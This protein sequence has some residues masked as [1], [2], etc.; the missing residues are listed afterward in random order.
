MSSN[1][2]SKLIFRLSQ[3]EEAYKL[4]GHPTSTFDITTLFARFC[5]GQV[6]ALPWSDTAPASETS[7]ISSQLAKLNELGFLTINSQPAVDGVRSDDKVH[8]WGPSNGYV[9][10]KVGRF[11]LNTHPSDSLLC[12]CD[13]GIF[14]VFCLPGIACCATPVYR[15]RPQYHILCDQQARRSANQQSLRR[16]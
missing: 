5:L 2:S 4:W 10:Q 7:V 9:Y 8:G 12:I 6:P 16:P 1:N 11:Y 15:A 13:I 14:R 3:K